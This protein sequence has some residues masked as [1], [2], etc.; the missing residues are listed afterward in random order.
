MTIIN[1]IFQMEVDK[2]VEYDDIVRPHVRMW[3]F[4]RC[5]LGNTETASKMM[6]GS[7]KHDFCQVNE[8]VSR[9]NDQEKIMPQ[10]ELNNIC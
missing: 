4:A 9:T 3:Q 6:E 7:R 10:R 5:V 8:K 1:L 2:M